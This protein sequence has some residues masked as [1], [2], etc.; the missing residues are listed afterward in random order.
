MTWAQSLTQL[1]SSDRTA[2]FV[3]QT[4]IS[5][6]DDVGPAISPSCS[7]SHESASARGVDHIGSETDD[8]GF[9]PLPML[10]SSIRSGKA[11][12]PVYNYDS[13]DIC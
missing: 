12:S 10:H 11:R 3:A 2:P 9:D 8:V 13:C 7:V 6:P 5:E 1:H 4:D